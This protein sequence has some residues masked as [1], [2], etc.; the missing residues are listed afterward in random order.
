MSD[1]RHSVK[2]HE[3]VE[4]NPP[5]WKDPPHWERPPAL[6]KLAP[7]NQQHSPVNFW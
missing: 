6:K 4:K 5:H 2:Q 7:A 1:N 3:S